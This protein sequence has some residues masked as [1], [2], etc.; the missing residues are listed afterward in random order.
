MYGVELTPDAP[1]QALA[2]RAAV[3]EAAGFEAAVASG[4]Y[5]NRGQFQALAGMAETT[6]EIHLGPGVANPYETHPVSLASRVATLAERTD[7]RALFGIGAGDAATLSNLGVERERPLRRVLE[8]V[9]V[10]RRLWAGER[11]EHDGTFRASGAGLNYGVDPIPTYVGAQGPHMTRMA[12]KHADGVFY[13]GAH[14]ADLAW[15]AERVEEGLAERPTDR[16]E[17]TFLA[18][19]SASVAESAERARAV[20]RRPVAFVTTS[21][22]EAVLARHDIDAERAERVGERIAA[23]AFEEADD[24]VTPAMLEAFCVA[25]TPA[26][27]ADRIDALRDHVDGVVFASPLGPDIEAG[28]GL[29]AEARERADGG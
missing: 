12:A 6:E 18:Y 19:A 15:A 29:L 13:N 24:L 10:A 3:A 21:A 16:G 26:T 28:I 25:G 20:A 14:P 7:G 17:F 8:T 11:V 23:G 4:H 22:P 2:D 5:N 9:R 27:V 1:V